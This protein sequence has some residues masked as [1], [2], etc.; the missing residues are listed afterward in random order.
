MNVIRLAAVLAVS[1]LLAAA[2]S[3]GD[4]AAPAVTVPTAEATSTT[5]TTSTSTSTSS[6]STTSTT[7]TSSTT[8]TEAPVETTDEAQILDVIERYWRTILNDAYDPPNPS[9]ELWDDLTTPE[10]RTILAERVQTRIDNGEGVAAFDLDQPF[11]TSADVTVVDALAIVFMCLRSESRSFDLETGE[12]VEEVRRVVLRRMEV[13]NGAEGW[14]VRASE[15]IETFD[16]G[17]E[18][19]CADS[20]SS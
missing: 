12:T 2:C 18:G 13:A 5:S 9:P 19:Q 1:A 15:T 7:T 4:D 20:L 16:E 17:Q 11:V 3:S 6:T 10:N 14:L 8:T